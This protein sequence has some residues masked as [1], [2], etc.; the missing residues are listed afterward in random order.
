MDGVFHSKD[1]NEQLGASPTSVLMKEARS[2][3]CNPVLFK[4]KITNTGG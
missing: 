2:K 4:N 1:Q 3:L